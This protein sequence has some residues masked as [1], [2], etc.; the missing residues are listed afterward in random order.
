MSERFGQY[1][2][3]PPAM[4]EPEVPLQE[5][6][7]REILLECERLCSLDVREV[8][9]NRGPVIDKALRFVGILEPS[10]WCTAIACLVLQTAAV[11]A[12]AVDDTCPDYASGAKLVRWA[13][14]NPELC[15]LVWEAEDLRPGDIGIMGATAAKAARIARGSLASGHTVIIA[16]RVAAGRHKLVP[17]FEGNT[18]AAG[19]REGD[20]FCARHRSVADERWVCGI[21]FR[22]VPRKVVA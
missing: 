6:F 16:G 9:W 2:I 19:S 5:R 3:C 13:L 4:P 1:E 10:P 15:E 18:N 20:T 14:A 22:A 21:R 8:A 12:G 7:V 17:T 11:N